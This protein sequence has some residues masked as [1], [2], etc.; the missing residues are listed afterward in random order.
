MS[1]IKVEDLT[2]SYPGSFD[3][4]FEHASFQMDTDWKLGFVGRNGRGKTTLFRLLMGKYEYSGRIQSSVQF[5]YFPYPVKDRSRLVSDILPEIAPQAED[6]ELMRELS[7]LQVDADVVYRPFDTLSNG[8]QTK[9]LLAA[10][11]CNEGHF[12]LIDEP[13]NHLDTRARELT[14][15]YLKRKKGFILVSHD[16][17]FLDGCVDHIL[18]LNRASI[19]VQSGNFSAWMENFQMQQEAE[20]ER[21]GKLQKDIRRLKNSARR[22]ATWSDRVEAS[23]AGA[24][25]KGFV[26]HKAAKMMKR[27][28]SIEARQKQ[29]AEEKSGLLKNFERKEDLKIHPLTYRAETLLSFSGVAAC[30]D[31]K[32]VSSPV[33]FS[34]KRGQRIV[35]DGK[36]G[37]GKSSLLKLLAGAPIEHTGEIHVASGLVI[38][39]VPQDASGLSGR[40]SAF[41]E[42]RGIDETL[43]MTILRKMDFE[44]TQFDKDIRDFS[45][46]Q[47]KKVLIAGSLCQEA[48]LYVW[49]EP[50]NFIDIYSRMQIEDLIQQFRPTMIFVEHDAVFRDKIATEVVQLQGGTVHA[51]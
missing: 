22:S 3:N 8:E 1:M 16:R 32:P 11:F 15:A 48:H 26:G 51:E 29:A 14:A 35:L 28:K 25:D 23:K 44:R 6:W 47:K 42:E 18:S 17:R 19:D 43:F 12:L 10:L 36:N 46:G 34:V 30:Y 13:T 9:V 40:L 2:F 38:S 45:E 49:D 20:L 7:Y 24:A 21:N 50:L 33:S 39:F 41:A 37:S 27:S 4:I 31:G 5:D